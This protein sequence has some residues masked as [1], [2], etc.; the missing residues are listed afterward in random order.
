MIQL[1]ETAVNKYKNNGKATAG[2]VLG[3]IGVVVSLVPLFGAPVNIV[4]LVMGILGLKSENKVRAKV[5]I[6][7]CIIGLISTIAWAI[8]GAITVTKAMK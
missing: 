1:G 4:G 5:G 6:V 2:L 8:Y 3:I 7:L